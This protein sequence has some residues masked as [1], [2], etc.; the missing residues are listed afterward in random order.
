MDTSP[1]PVAI[2]RFENAARFLRGLGL[3][4]AMPSVEDYEAITQYVHDLRHAIATAPTERSHEQ[5]ALLYEAEIADHDRIGVVQ[6]DG[7]PT[8]AQR[9]QAIEAHLNEVQRLEWSD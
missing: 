1:V 3:R 4:G 5:W 6:F 9:R 7:S 8:D 2:E